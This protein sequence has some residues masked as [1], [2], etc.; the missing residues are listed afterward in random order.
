MLRLAFPLRIGK[1]SYRR[2]FYVSAAVLVFAAVKLYFWALEARYI[3]SE[4]ETGRY[5]GMCE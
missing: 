2:L 5:V 4:E 3:C 1:W